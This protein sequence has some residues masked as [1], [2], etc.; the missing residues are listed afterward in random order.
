MT[1]HKRRLEEV[2]QTYSSSD[3]A[4]H[5][6]YHEWKSWSFT[7]FTDKL[8]GKVYCGDTS[9]TAG[10][11]VRTDL[12]APSREVWHK[13]DKEDFYQEQRRKWYI[14]RFLHSISLFDQPEVAET[15][16]KEREK[17]HSLWEGK[18]WEIISFLAINP[19]WMNS[20]I[21]VPSFF[22]ILTTFSQISL[23][24][25]RFQDHSDKWWAENLWRRSEEWERKKMDFKEVLLLNLL[26]GFE[27][28]C[29]CLFRQA[30]TLV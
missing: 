7:R 10:L 5:W 20:G 4:R 18:P 28:H 23:F 3:D 21:F 6:A 17:R 26:N 12:S 16:K 9:A 8:T 14:Y 2:V 1:S 15:K 13:S 11:A 22:H 30:D 24:T 19:D 29:F 27:S 25:P